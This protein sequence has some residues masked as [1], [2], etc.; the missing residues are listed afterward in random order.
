V[1]S[2]RG[3]PAGYYEQCAEAPEGE[4]SMDLAALLGS[5]VGIDVSGLVDRPGRI[6]FAELRS[7]AAGPRLSD[8]AKR[9]IPVVDLFTDVRVSIDA[10][11]VMISTID[12]ETVGFRVEAMLRDHSMHFEIGHVLA[13]GSVDWRAPLRLLGREVPGGSLAIHALDFL[14]FEDFIG[15]GS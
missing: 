15:Q 11:V 10:E 14:T 7:L 12:G 1:R 9:D 13:D 3:R 6:G 5:L 8:I 2:G 4:R